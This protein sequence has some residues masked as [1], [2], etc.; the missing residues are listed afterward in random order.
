MNMY[1]EN[2]KILSNFFVMYYVYGISGPSLLI[3]STNPNHLPFQSQISF[4][5]YVL[6]VR[7]AVEPY[8]SDF[9]R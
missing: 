1:V 4:F 3:E 5:A 2:L 8:G 7:A 6:A 9:I